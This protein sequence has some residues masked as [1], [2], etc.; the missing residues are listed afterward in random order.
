MAIIESIVFLINR[1]LEE[2]EKSL[3]VT[4]QLRVSGG[5]ANLDGLCQ[6]LAD[7]SGKTI[8]RP[9]TTEATARGL[10]FLIAG[11]PAQWLAAEHEKRFTPDA[12]PQLQ[13]RFQQWQRVLQLTINEL[14]P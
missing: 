13:Q 6:R 1:N 9:A 7:L 2:M 3:P 8:T 10:A 14:K 5:L 4:T 12:N 11:Q